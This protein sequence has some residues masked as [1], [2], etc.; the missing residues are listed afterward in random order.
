VSQAEIETLRT[1]YAAFNRG[2]RE[3]LFA[4]AHPD[5]E[6]KTADRFTNPGTYRGVETLMSFFDDLFAPFEQVTA[7]PTKLVDRGDR[8]AV[9]L[10]VRLKPHG[11]D[12]VLEN[13]IGHLWTFR[14]GKVLRLEIFPEREKALEAIG[15]SEQE[16]RAAAA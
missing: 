3:S 14:D 4:A 6:F 9:L 5:F 16:A 11:S 12:A 7:E 1:G 10:H 2:E 15:M 13:R 8:I